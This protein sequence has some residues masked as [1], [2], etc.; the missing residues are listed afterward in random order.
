[1]RSANRSP[2]PVRVGD[3][4]LAALPRLDPDEPALVGSAL[5][6]VQDAALAGTVR[7]LMSKDLTARRPRG[8]VALA[9][10]GTVLAAA[11]AGC[12]S[13]GTDPAAPS[14]ST[15]TVEPAP[16]G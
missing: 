12:A 11:L 7:G 14:R 8:L 2:S 9:L 4:L 10:G 6:P 3:V 1:M 5:A 13:G 15:A 16:V